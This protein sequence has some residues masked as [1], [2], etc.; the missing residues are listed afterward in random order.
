MKDMEPIAHREA[1]SEA[2]IKTLNDLC[3][4]SV[5]QHFY[6]AGGTGLALQIGHRRSLDLDFFTGVPFNQEEL[7]ERM[8]PRF[9]EFELVAK[10]NET[11]HAHI[12]HIKVSFLGYAYPI[13]F[14]FA[15]FG[16]ADI[17]DARDI[18]C[19]KVSA[20]AGRGTKRDFIDLYAISRQ[21]GLLQILD[22]FR[23]KYTRANY[24]RVHILK[25]MTYFDEAE[26]DPMPDMLIELSW[27]EVKTFFLKEVPRLL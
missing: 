27:A 7:L 26:Q 3:Q 4:A 8:I 18:A 11:L 1:I 6:L 22:W 23:E 5:L 19:M 16:G 15:R 21:Y 10:D 12:N 14:P 20:I 17:A 2:V 24:S 13:L 25:S 9:G